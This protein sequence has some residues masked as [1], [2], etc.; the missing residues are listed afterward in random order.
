LTRA[1]KRDTVLTSLLFG[2]GAGSAPAQA[3][4]SETCPVLFQYSQ[5]RDR[6]PFDVWQYDSMTVLRYDG[7]I[8]WRDL[9]KLRAVAT[10]KQ[11]AT[12]AI[13]TIAAIRGLRWSRRSRGGTARRMIPHTISVS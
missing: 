9:L 2:A 6:L 7:S 12:A 8:V 1:A 3:G 11:R 4:T 5:R 13:A 10:R